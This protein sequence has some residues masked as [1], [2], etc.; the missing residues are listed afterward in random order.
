MPFAVELQFGKSM[1][2]VRWVSE[3]ECAP[4]SERQIILFSIWR[5]IH[6]IADIKM[7]YIITNCYLYIYLFIF[8][9]IFLWKMAEKK[10]SITKTKYGAIQCEQVEWKEKQRKE[11]ARLINAAEIQNR[12]KWWSESPNKRR[13]KQRQRIKRAVQLR[14]LQRVGASMHAD[15]DFRL[16]KPHNL[17]FS[18]HYTMEL[19]S[20]SPYTLCVRLCYILHA[21]QPR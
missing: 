5:S 12:H 2:N 13:I 6:F 19:W 15:F 10:L 18:R 9:R 16:T 14:T 1:A 7:W 4:E 8:R 20:A 11:P 3:R 21:K 17:M